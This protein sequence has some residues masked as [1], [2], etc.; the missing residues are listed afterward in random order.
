MLGLSC[1]STHALTRD[2]YYI[3]SCS[4]HSRFPFQVWD[5]G[6]V[7]TQYLAARPHV[8]APPKRCIELGAGTGAAG[9]AAVLL[10][11]QSVL[12]TDL[13]VR[14][15]ASAACDFRYFCG[16]DVCIFA[17]AVGAAE[18]RRAFLD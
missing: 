13:E 1:N 15:Q 7:L 6:L 11:A 10:G 5:A 8:I 14:E 3:C 18:A 12:V 4:L 2:P 16:V 17:M 9:I